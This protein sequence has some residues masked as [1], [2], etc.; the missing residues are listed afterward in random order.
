M[1]ALLSNKVLA[2]RGCPIGS[3][4]RS[5]H[6][7]IGKGS[8]RLYALKKQVCKIEVSLEGKSFKDLFGR[9]ER[10]KGFVKLKG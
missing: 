1:L 5:R 6:C 9:I 7:R 8:A 2:P 10:I 4:K 3:I